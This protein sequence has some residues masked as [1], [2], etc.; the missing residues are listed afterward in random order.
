MQAIEDFGEPAYMIVPGDLHRMDAKIWK[1][2]YPNMIVVAP[3]ASA[4]G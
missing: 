2:R 3:A 4:R 1:D